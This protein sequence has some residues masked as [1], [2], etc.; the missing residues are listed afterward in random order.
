MLDG[1]GL[2][3][4][5]A[6]FVV[7]SGAVVLA[8]VSLARH[9]DAIAV[10]TGLGGLVVGMLLVAGA[11][12]LP[13]IAT[14]VSATLEGS[15]D[16]AIGGILGS[17][18][19]NMAIL[20][21]IDLLRRRTVWPSVGL[22]HARVAAIALGLTAILLLGIASTVRLEVGW[23]GAESILIVAA[24]VASAAW[25]Q[26]ADRAESRAASELRSRTPAPEVDDAV[27][28]HPTG[29]SA[30]RP[31]HTLRHHVLRFGLATGVV[32]VA[33]PA[34][35]LAAGGIAEQT[36]IAETFIG[37]TLLAIVT[38]LPELVASI[39]AVQIGAADLAVGNLFGSNAFNATIVFATDAVYTQGPILAAVS[40]QQVV[41]GLGAVLLMAI[42]LGGIVHGARSRFERGEPDAILLLIGYV[43]MLWL[44]WA[45]G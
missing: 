14:G 18:M 1:L 45:G 40:P 23:I 44:L 26:R 22:G 25:V 41:A 33:A 12:S 2:P 35:A 5:I 36:G 21:V 4:L 27:L 37:A 11:T 6:I 39:A 32:V 17:S 16:L 10:Q 15:P 38:S 34:V 3:A 9:G 24:Y 31:A 8:G 19:A 28:L 42:A 7:S 20:A 30:E 29:W 13:E 43:G